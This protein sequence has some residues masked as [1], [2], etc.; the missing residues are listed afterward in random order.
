MNKY[1]FVDEK[2]EHRHELDGQPLIG[3]SSVASVLA[4]P[5][6]W[7]ASGLAVMELGVPDAKIF[8][9]IKN[10][11]ATQEEID[12]LQ[13]SC[14][15]FL[16]E[17]RT[18]DTKSYVKLLDK[19]YRA[20]NTTLKDKAEAGTDLHAELE[21]FV[22]WVMK[23][24]SDPD[25]SI[26]DSMKF[27]DRIEPFILWTEKNVK[28]FL[29]SEAHC[30]SSKYWLGGISDVGVEMN[31]GKFGILDFKSSKDVYLSQFWQCA[32]YAIQMEENGL[33]DKDG[34]KTGDLEKPIEFVGIVA[35]GMEKVEPKFNYDMTACK[36]NFLHEVALYKALNI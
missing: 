35:F 36:E 18:M 29:F 31:D 7:W 28:R 34:N 2:G 9:K 17:L 15:E 6:T 8:T 21:R 23:G 30:F 5:L 20:H 24:E 27:S 13:S 10:K 3:T 12:T 33:F 14:D 1:K 16:G 32:G 4:K 26:L 25:K 11:T 22:K 19:A